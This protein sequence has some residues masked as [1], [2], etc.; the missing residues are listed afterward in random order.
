MNEHQYEHFRRSQKEEQYPEEN[1]CENPQVEAL[2]GDNVC[3]NCGMVHGR[4]MVN[5]ERRAYT[6]EEVQNRRQTAP[7]WREF[8]PR[9]TIPSAKK[10]DKM[11]AERKTL[12]SRLS[13]IQN[14]LVSSIER[15]FWEA[16]PKLKMLTSMLNIPNFIEE[17]AWKIYSEV[18]KKKLTM[19]RSIKGFI[20][21]SLYAAIRVHEYPRILDEVCKPLMIS[22]HKV[23]QSLGLILKEILPELGLKYHPITAEKLIYRLGSDL[24]IPILLQKKAHDALVNASKH[25]LPRIG[26]D[27]RGF[28]AASIYIAARNTKHQKTQVQIAEKAGITEVTLRSRKK[29]IKEYFNKK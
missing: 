18:A 9:T 24:N 15:N 28:A 25:G 17:T 2:E 3:V 10:E 20:A 21:A 12:F 16:K 4:D 14:S 11:S 23:I 22:R 26:K 7:R 5:L 6:S 1:C 13:K 27:P 8:G 29:E 19:G